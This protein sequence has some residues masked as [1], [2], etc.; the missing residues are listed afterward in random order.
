VGEGGLKEYDLQYY[1]E[2][3]HKSMVGLHGGQEVNLK[4]NQEF[5]RKFRII[6]NKSK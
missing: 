2:E 6:F 5:Q 1:Q 3:T 4:E